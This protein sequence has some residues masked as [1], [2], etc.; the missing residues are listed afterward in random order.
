MV[1]SRPQV[2]SALRRPA[3]NANQP[4][5]AAPARLAIEPIVPFMI[6][7]VSLLSPESR[8]NGPTSEATIES[9]NL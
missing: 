6:A 7:I 8:M 1:C 5:M 4:P 9:P 2:S 3:R